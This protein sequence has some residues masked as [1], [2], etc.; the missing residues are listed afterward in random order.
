M[1]LSQVSLLRKPNR[2][3]L[4]TEGA[5]MLTF[6]MRFGSLITKICWIK[7]PNSQAGCGGALLK[8]GTVRFPWNFD[9]YF[10]LA[11]LVSSITE[12]TGKER[13]CWRG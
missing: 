2:R 1:I 6:K 13:S 3:E 11:V 7:G 5:R 12:S 4:V 8:E 9:L 10:H